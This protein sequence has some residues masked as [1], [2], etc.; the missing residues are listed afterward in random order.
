[1]NGVVAVDAACIQL[2]GADRPGLR[3]AGGRLPDRGVRN[4]HH[5]RRT[6]ISLRDASPVGDSCRDETQRPLQPIIRLID[7][8]ALDLQTSSPSVSAA[9]HLYTVSDRHR[10]SREQVPVA[11]VRVGQC[12]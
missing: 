1:M 2:D 3:V 4:I 7:Q 10:G 6:S 12:R 9:E 11:V 5:K 8:P